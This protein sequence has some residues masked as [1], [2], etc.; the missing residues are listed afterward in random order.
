MTESQICKIKHALFAIQSVIAET[1]SQARSGDC[2]VLVYARRH[3]SN[4]HPLGDLSC[5]EL[6]DRYETIAQEDKLP[7]LRRGIFLSRLPIA[8]SLAYG[9]NK[10]NNIARGDQRVRGFKGIGFRLAEE[11]PEPEL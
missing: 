9:I 11:L 1:S 4:A 5:A 8:M 10:S 2:P 3:L 7:P 6:W